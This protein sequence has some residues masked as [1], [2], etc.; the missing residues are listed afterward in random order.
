VLRSLL[1]L[2]PRDVPVRVA[3]RNTLAIV[4][5]LAVGLAAGH[6]ALGLA[7]STGA[8]NTMFTDQPGPYRLRLQ[9]ML[10][11]AIAA[12]LAAFLGIMVGDRLLPF[13]IAAFVVA[14]AG[15]MLVA[16]GPM[17]GRVGLTSMIVLVVTAAMEIPRDQGA[18]VALLICGGGALQALFAIAA[19]PL[20]RYR[21]ER[22]ALADVLGQLA[23]AARAR[24]DA[25]QPPAVSQAAMEALEELHGD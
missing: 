2:K 16:L 17:A 23:A 18:G 13:T 14:F 5:P 11:A 9:R 19:W 20:Q 24:P 12:G 3:L 21:P 1:A 7:V 4:A 15:G 6:E 22:F 25:A 10:L 8:L